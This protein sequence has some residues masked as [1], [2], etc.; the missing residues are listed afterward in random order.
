MHDVHTLVPPVDPL[1][2]IHK[3]QTI[4]AR[5]CWLFLSCGDWLVDL[6]HVSWCLFFVNYDRCANIVGSSLSPMHACQTIAYTCR[7]RVSPSS[8]RLHRVSHGFMMGLPGIDRTRMVY[9]GALW[10]CRRRSGTNCMEFEKGMQHRR[11]R[12]HFSGMPFPF[13][14]LLGIVGIL[15]PSL[16]AHC[17]HCLGGWSREA[18]RAFSNLD[19]LLF[20]AD[21]CSFGCRIR[22]ILRGGVFTL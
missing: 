4:T 22:L 5:S 2:A 19:T 21:P 15:V 20:A 7:R 6:S 18:G 1:T 9:G 10:H 17:R 3:G 8:D 16:R 14:L 11:R 12:M 13:F